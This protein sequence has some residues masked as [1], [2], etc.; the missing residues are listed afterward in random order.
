MKR[1]IEISPLAQPEGQ[2][3]RRFTTHKERAQWFQ[4]RASF[5]LREANSEKLARARDNFAETDHKWRSVGPTNVS[6]RLTSIAVDP[7]DRQRLFVGAAAGGVWRSKDGGRHWETRWDK[8]A[9][10]NIGSLAIDP[11][12]PDIIYCGTGEANLSADSYPGSGVYRSTDGGDS[13]EIFSRGDEQSV[14]FPRRIGALAV[15]PVRPGMTR[16][17]AGSVRHDDS[18]SARL[19]FSEVINRDI[20]IW[21]FIPNFISSENYRCHAVVTHKNSAGLVFAAIDARGV[22]SGIWRSKDHGDT[23]SQLSEGLPPGERFGRTSLAMTEA[24]PNFVYALVESREGVLGVFQSKDCGETWKTISDAHF[25]REQQAYYNNCIAVDPEHPEWVYCG[26]MNIHRTKD[27]GKNWEQ[28]TEA[29][30]QLGDP[31]YAHSDHHALAIPKTGI[32]YAANDSGLD[33]SE[34]GGDHWENR[35]KGLVTTMF[36][37]VDVAP[38][39][40]DFY[41]GGAQD[42]GTLIHQSGAGHGE[43]DRVLD[44]DG[45][46]MIFAPDDPENL[47]ASS[48]NMDLQ[49]HAAGGGW[50]GVTPYQATA[51]ERKKVWLAFLAMDMSEGRANPRTVFAGS[52]RIWKTVDDGVSWQAVSEELDGS[53]VSAIEVASANPRFVY[54]GT[55]KGGF[56]RSIDGGNNWSEN[57]GGPNLPGRIIT[58]IESHPKKADRLMVTIGVTPADRMIVRL[59]RGGV[60]TPQ[61][62]RYSHVFISMDAG[63]TWHIADPGTPDA[64]DLDQQFQLP[65][66]P[67]N[68]LTFET[69]DPFRVFAATDIGVFEGRWNGSFYQWDNIS[70]NLPNVM[71]TDIVYHQRTHTLTVGTYGRGIWRLKLDRKKNAA[72]R[73]ATAARGAKP[74]R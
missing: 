42:N 23:W 44:A 46:W 70:G 64:T 59:D 2:S 60:V 58:R 40:G 61:K 1:R 21:Q 57:L 62:G 37:D 35:S 25:N 68:S 18:D 6:G 63:S 53:A 10:L 73:R 71:V 12:S 27:G 38:S 11:E 48:Q 52:T 19:I 36:Y 20:P 47:W 65:D 66:V 24:D 8:L 43:F 22:I 51:E 67:H 3:N 34:D 30:L 55:H 74:R 14:L 39:D 56:Y 69:R 28:I 26:L 32:I 9:S 7:R 33:V 50:S 29:K 13:W 54:A 49:H 41:G 15:V 4:E 17:F 16:V 45:G 31:R 72:K 5:P